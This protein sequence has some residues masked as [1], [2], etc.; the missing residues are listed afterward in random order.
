MI[1]TLTFLLCNSFTP[2][3]NGN[4]YGI[5]NPNYTDPVNF[6]TNFSDINSTYEYFDVYSPAITSRYAEVYWTM[7]PKVELPKNIIDRF[8]KKTM[9]IVGY[10]TDQV[11]ANG[12]SVP[13]TWAYNHHYEAYLRSIETNLIKLENKIHNDYGQYNHGA[14]E[15]WKLNQ[16]DPLSS[17]FF[18]GSL[19]ITIFLRNKF[20]KPGSG[21]SALGLG[22]VSI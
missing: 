19:A 2:N 18:S 4:V 3:M 17:L 12:S 7:M 16:T 14:K 13:I 8:F 6:S 20:N 9:A 21:V 22:R 1:S 11:F 5:S 15:I 10:E